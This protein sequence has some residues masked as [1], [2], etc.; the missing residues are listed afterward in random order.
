MKMG[1]CAGCECLLFTGIQG[2]EHDHGIHGFVVGPDQRLYFNFGNQAQRICD[3]SGKLIVD[4]AG[5]QVEATRSPYQQGMVFRC[6]L[7][8][9]QFETLGWNFRNNWELC[10]DSFG[11]IWQSDN[12]DDGYRGTRINYVMEFGN[13]GYRDEITGQ[14]WK[15]DRAGIEGDLPSRHWHLNDPGVV[16]N[17]LQT[18]DGSP[19]GITLYEGDLLP[20]TYRNQII[21]CDP[22]FNVVRAYPLKR[23]GTGYSASIVN[24]V[25]GARDDVPSC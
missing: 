16:P 6:N 1:I 20:S 8:G 22:G 14:S 18:G 23:S 4:E 2:V 21:H 24:L 25:N 19:A 11:T 3:P 13:Y 7:D 5:N 10:I 17:L 12:D 15:A 9:S